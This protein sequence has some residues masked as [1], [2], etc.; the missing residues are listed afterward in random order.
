MRFRPYFHG[1]GG[2][3][4]VPFFHGVGGTGAVPFF[5]GVG[6]TGAVPFAIITAPSAWLVTMVLKPIA[7]VKIS[8]TK[9]TT[10]SF[11][12]IVPPRYTATTEVLYC[13]AHQ[14]QVAHRTD[15]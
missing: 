6:G 12:D 14:C 5:H 1:V 9:S 7:P 4:A 10:V 3:G 11:R 15:L 13:L 8:M 2:T